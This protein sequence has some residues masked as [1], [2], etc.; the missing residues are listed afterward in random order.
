MRTIMKIRKTIY[1]I[2]GFLLFCGWSDLV[3]G[4]TY[5][6]GDTVDNF[7]ATVCVNDTGFE[8]GYWDYNTDG[9][10]KI[11]WM[12]LFTSWWPSC[13]AE[14]PLT[15]NISQVYQSQPVVVIAA[16][17][18]WSSYSCEGWANAFGITY[19]I[20]DDDNNTIY[21]L[22][23][24]GYI[25]HNIVIDGHGVVLYSQSGFNQTAIISTINEAL[26]N[27][28]ADNDGV[29]NGS[30][31]CPDVYNPY[32]EDEDEDGIGDA[33]DN[34]NSLI[35]SLGNING[36]DAINIIDVLML[37]DVVLGENVNE[38]MYSASDITLDGYV[39]VLDVLGL[40]QII[41]G[42]NQQMAVQFLEGMLHPEEFERLTKQLTFLNG[43][44]KLTVWPNPSN[45][46]M[47]ISG[48]GYV[49]IYN[50]RGQV[51]Q[52][53]YLS[54]KRH[55]WDT[56]KLPSGIY[57][58]MNNGETTTVTLIKWLTIKS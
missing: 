35:F 57:Y 10:H 42:G 38:C 30:D 51:I 17:S 25:P 21:P 44:E 41:L 7:G 32:Q 45:D 1:Y 23:G 3:W 9:L 46:Y 26:E 50:M 53:L 20:L 5:T 14:A 22:F 37:I 4:Q 11:V 29:F 19:P 8:D 2:L 58:L 36:D 55:H 31:N 15:E 34:C 13:Q 56:R 43:P 24:T 16:G 54:N 33:C 40:V 18:D 49:T 27:L 47:T 28:D 48:Y 52:E 6:V 12:N 39:N